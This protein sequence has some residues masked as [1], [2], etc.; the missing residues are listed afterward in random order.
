MWELLNMFTQGVITPMFMIKHLIYCS[1]Y[2]RMKLKKT[3][4]YDLKSSTIIKGV[5]YRCLEKRDYEYL[6]NITSFV[7][8]LLQ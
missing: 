5:Y 3:N 1:L 6:V 4:S 7:L 8:N 2:S